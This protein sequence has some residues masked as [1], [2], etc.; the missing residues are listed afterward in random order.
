[1]LM[2]A[3]TL[4]AWAQ[5]PI[6][7]PNASFESPVTV[8]AF[9]DADEWDETGPVGE[10]PQLPGVIDT[11]DTGVFFNSPV[12]ENGLPSPFFITNGDGMQIAFIGADDASTIAFFQQLDATYEVGGTYTLNLLVGESFFFPPLTYNPNDPP[13]PDPD[14]ALLEVSLYYA[15]TNGAKITIA[16]HIVSTDELP[17]GPNNGV[18]LLDVS[19]T[20][21]TVQAADAWSSVPIGVMIRPVL[22]LSGV[23]NLDYARLEVNCTTGI[24]GDA[25]FDGDV[26]SADHAA[27]TRCMTGPQSG[28]RPASCQPCEFARLDA[29]G[30]NDLDLRDYAVFMGNFGG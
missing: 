15:D 11:L 25:D 10:S 9:P 22:G 18:L 20:G 7:I 19:T 24:I 8:F 2:S 12:D 3:T 21:A 5:V 30:D 16:Q 6:T 14:P 1:M 26:D 29:N 13:P 28:V 4:T 23:W 27:F 17:D